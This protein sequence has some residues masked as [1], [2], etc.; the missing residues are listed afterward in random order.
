[1]SLKRQAALVIGIGAACLIAAGLL[2]GEQQRQ[3][4]LNAT[5]ST[6][7]TGTVTGVEVTTVSSPEY[8]PQ[9]LQVRYGHQQ[10]AQSDATETAVAYVDQADQLVLRS[11]VGAD[12]TTLRYQEH[13]TYAADPPYHLAWA[14]AGQYEVD[15]SP[16]VLH[17]SQPGM[18]WQDTGS[19]T[20]QLWMT[21][22]AAGPEGTSIALWSGSSP[23]ALTSDG[24]FESPA[25]VVYSA[26]QLASGGGSV[27]LI[28][29][30]T[31]ESGTSKLIV[32]WVAP[33]PGRFTIL[34]PDPAWATFQPPHLVVDPSGTYALI[35]LRGEHHPRASMDLKDREAELIAYRFTRDP[36]APITE[37]T[38]AKR[39]PGVFYERP[40]LAVSP[41]GTCWVFAHASITYA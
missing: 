12:T 35:A 28:Y 20:P 8:P 7:K 36:A 9:P 21:A 17:W 16:G 39:S 2:R 5:S 34:S 30:T 37:T 33:D 10:L 38:I 40:V 11:S 18:V 1:M 41:S 14:P 6:P 27:A 15:T 31:D 32:G 29:R 23:E 4:K 25:G 3:A 24:L 19:G 26:S 13:L 22:T